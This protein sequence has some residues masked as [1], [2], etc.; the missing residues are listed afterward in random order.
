MQSENRTQYEQS[1]IDQFNF[2]RQ[3]IDKKYPT[4]FAVQLNNRLRDYRPATD[5]GGRFECR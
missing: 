2:C 4:N 3:L 5:F 1:K